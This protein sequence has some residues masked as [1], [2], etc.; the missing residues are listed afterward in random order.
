LILAARI[1]FPNFSVSS[2]RSFSEI[3][4]R[5]CNRNTSQVGEP[6]FHLGIG[7]G[8]LDLLVSRRALWRAHAVPLLAS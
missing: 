5:A 7:K 3:D 4:R 1:T 6:R 8:G 2:A